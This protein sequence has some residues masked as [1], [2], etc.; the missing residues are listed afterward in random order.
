MEKMD[1]KAFVFPNEQTIDNIVGLYEEFRKRDS[2]DDSVS[3]AILTLTAVIENSLY[4]AITDYCERAY[5]VEKMKKEYERQE[6]KRK[7][8]EERKKNCDPAY[9][10]E[11]MRK[12]RE[13]L[14]RRK[15][16][17]SK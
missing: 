13:D 3:S 10:A 6:Q 8:E 16:E 14:L 7:D 9:G 17:A 4:N 15:N 11:V 2:A 1:F 12:L 5:E